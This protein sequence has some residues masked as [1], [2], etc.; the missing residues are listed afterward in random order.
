MITNL[1]LTRAEMM[2]VCQCQ[3][4]GTDAVVLSAE[5][6]VCLVSNGKGFNNSIV[7]S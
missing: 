6:A 1:V 7:C 3:I 2:E 5:T 4:E